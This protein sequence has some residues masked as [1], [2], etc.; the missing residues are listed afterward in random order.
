MYRNP[1]RGK[2]APA[3]EKINKLLGVHERL[4]GFAERCL[5]WVR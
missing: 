3:Q 5:Y 2:Q 4:A 1:K